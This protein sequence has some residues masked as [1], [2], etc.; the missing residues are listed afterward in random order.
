ML[1]DRIH[2]QVLPAGDDS[3]EGN[4]EEGNCILVMWQLLKALCERNISLT[5]Y[6]A[7]TMYV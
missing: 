1:I 2:T 7:Y 6:I 4:I 5:L 3:C